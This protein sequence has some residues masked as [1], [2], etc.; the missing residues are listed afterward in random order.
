MRIHKDNLHQSFEGWC[1]ADSRSFVEPDIG[2]EWHR[3]LN[4]KGWLASLARDG[5]TGW[6]P[7]QRFIFVKN[8]R[9]IGAALS[10]LGLRLVGPV[11]C[12]FGT[13]EQ[14]SRFLPP[15]LRGEHYWC[16][17]YSEPGSV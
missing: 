6:T 11:I 3:I 1:Q 2:M 16:Q 15:L 5:G 7:T 17:G 12:E 8:V 10:I 9:S 13:E 14:K 4:E